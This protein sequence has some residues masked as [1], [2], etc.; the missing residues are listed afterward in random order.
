MSRIADRL[1]QYCLL[2][3]VQFQNLGQLVVIK[4]ELADKFDADYW[5]D[6]YA[7]ALGID[8]QLVIPNSQVAL[9][10]QQRAEKQEQAENLAAAQSLSQVA[11]NVGS[12]GEMRSASPEQIMGQF[13]GY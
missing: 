8:P 4:P 2:S 10:R 12:M 9:I 5:A 1:C 3:I 11:K 7:D 6:Y 13:A